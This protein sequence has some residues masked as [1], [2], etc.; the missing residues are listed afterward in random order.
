MGWNDRLPED[1][2]IPYESQDDRDAY[3]NW[4][5]YMEFLRAEEEAGGLTSN[6]IQPG[7]LP[8]KETQDNAEILARLRELTL[9]TERKNEDQNSR[10]PAH[11]QIESDN[12]APHT[13]PDR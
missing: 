5:M 8:V 9:K 2:Y 3:D 7:D 6:N 13:A 10:Q 11:H 4:A 1:P 12:R